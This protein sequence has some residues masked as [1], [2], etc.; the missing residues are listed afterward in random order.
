MA[1]RSQGMDMREHL[2]KYAP[3]HLAR[4]LVRD[5]VSIDIKDMELSA[6]YLQVDDS[7]HPSAFRVVLPTVGHHRGHGNSRENSQAPLRTALLCL[8]RRNEKPWYLQAL[9]SYTPLTTLPAARKVS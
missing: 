6:A 3:V 9:A 5:I 8:P 1:K 7:V 2:V 4:V